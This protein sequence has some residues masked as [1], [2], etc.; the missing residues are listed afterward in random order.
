MQRQGLW[1]GAKCR[2]RVRS[3]KKVGRAGWRLVFASTRFQ[4]PIACLPFPENNSICLRKFQAAKQCGIAEIKLY[5]LGP[6]SH[7]EDG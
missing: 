1:E 3:A 2:L 7:L 4:K 6:K 5:S